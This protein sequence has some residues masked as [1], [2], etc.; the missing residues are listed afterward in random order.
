MDYQVLEKYNESL[1]LEAARLHK[2]Y[3]SYRS[4]LTSFGL[5]FIREIYK[6][7]LEGKQ[8]LIIACKN[9]EH[10]RGFVL[11]CFNTGSMFKVIK[12]KFLKYLF[13]VVPFVLKNPVIFIRILET[14]FYVK[15][16]NCPAGAELIVMIV[17]SQYRSQGIGNKF[18]TLLEAEFAKKNIYH[19]KVTVH[20][21]MERSNDFY[22]KNGFALYQQFNMYGVLWN[23]YTKKIGPI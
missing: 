15:K 9:G 12:K 23:L 14:L 10:L 17:N 22:R 8:G 16:E 7:V 13:I 5:K 18:I 11:G 2:E 6:D 21:D 19:Y 20:N 4:F 1:C 3:L